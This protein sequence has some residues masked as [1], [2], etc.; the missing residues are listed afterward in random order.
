MH[1]ISVLSGDISIATVAIFTI[2]FT[3]NNK[4]ILS[5]EISTWIT[6]LSCYPDLINFE[7]GAKILLLKVN[8]K[9]IFLSTIFAWKIL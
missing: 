4:I 6:E 1:K 2:S 5:F 8:F 3:S 7:L 9:G